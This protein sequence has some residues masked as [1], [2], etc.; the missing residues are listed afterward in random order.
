M[1]QCILLNSLENTAH[2]LKLAL[3]YRHYLSRRSIT[4]ESLGDVVLEVLLYHL[5][6]GH[7]AGNGSH[8][9]EKNEE[10]HF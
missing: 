3:L 1:T 10:S 5:I 4:D 6:R 9:G 7:S 2:F 8:N